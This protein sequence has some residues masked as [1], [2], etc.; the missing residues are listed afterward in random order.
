MDTQSPSP[1]SDP[2]VLDDH[3]EDVAAQEAK[4]IDGEENL[5]GNKKMLE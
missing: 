2:S 1:E 3:S 4:A 5:L